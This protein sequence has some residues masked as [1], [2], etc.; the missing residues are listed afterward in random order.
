MRV[1]VEQVIGILKKCQRIQKMAMA[2]EIINTDSIVLTCC[3]HYSFLGKMGSHEN[4]GGYS[5]YGTIK[6]K[7]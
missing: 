3:M 4:I 6:V 7:H 1:D 2:I 5:Q